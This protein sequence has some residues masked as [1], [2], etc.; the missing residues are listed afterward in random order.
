MPLARMT[1][2]ERLGAV[3]TLKECDRVPVGFPLSWF[4]GRHAGITMADFANDCEANASA[5]YK[6]YQDLGGFDILPSS[7]SRR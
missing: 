6:T 4:A 7:T 1:A 3:V 2:K 5:V